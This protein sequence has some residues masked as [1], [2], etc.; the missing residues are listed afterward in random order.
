[1]VR[2][3]SKLVNKNIFIGKKRTSMRL[4]PEMWDALAEIS[5]REGLSL[6]DLCMLVDKQRGDSSLT[7]ATRVFI[8]SYFRFAARQVQKPIIDSMQKLP[9][10]TATETASPLLLATAVKKP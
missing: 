1:M 9:R 6:H 3:Q 4:E 8:M 5:E 2:H 10:S 7:S